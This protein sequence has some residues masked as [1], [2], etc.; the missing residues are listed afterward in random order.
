MLWAL[1]KYF[2]FSSIAKHLQKINKHTH[3]HSSH[4]RLLCL[5]FNMMC[6]HI[7]L[8]ESK[9]FFLLLCR[10][11][12]L[13]CVLCIFCLRIT[14]FILEDLVLL[15]AQCNSLKLC[16][17]FYLQTKTDRKNVLDFVFILRVLGMCVCSAAFLLH[18]FLFF[19]FV[20]SHRWFRMNTLHR[21]CVVSLKLNGLLIFDVCLYVW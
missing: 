7:G 13:V 4:I 1:C 6:L 3:T 17:L 9:T 8:A 10:F 21:F 11:F 5:L 15:N 16:F 20:I 2:V 19:F 12:L 18:F 14:R